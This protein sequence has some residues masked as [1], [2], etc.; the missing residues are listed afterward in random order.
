[1]S[2]PPADFNGNFSFL[3]G[4]ILGVMGTKMIMLPLLLKAFGTEENF[5]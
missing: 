4:I 2:E 1:M 3:Q 5:T